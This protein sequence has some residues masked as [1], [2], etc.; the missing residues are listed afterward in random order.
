M[1]DH[2]SE[3]AGHHVAAAPTYGSLG[4]NEP[5]HKH[6]P[7]AAE[8]PAKED[9]MTRNGMNLKSFQVRDY[10]H[11]IVELDRSMKPRHLHMIAIGMFHSPLSKTRLPETCADAI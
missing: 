4:L 5:G 3:K 7:N 9:F 6:N 1:S 8:E 11:G 2:D 10:G